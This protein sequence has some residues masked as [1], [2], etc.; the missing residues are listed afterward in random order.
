MYDISNDVTLYALRDPISAD[1]ANGL[2]A[3]VLDLIGDYEAVV[4][5]YSYQSANGNTSYVREVQPDYAW[6]CSCAIFLIVLYC[7]FRLGA[8]IL[9]KK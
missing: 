6:L 9:C 2:K 3:V 4:V 8:A 5:E 7:T 1:D